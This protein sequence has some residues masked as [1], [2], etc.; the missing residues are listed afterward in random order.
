[1][2]ELQKPQSCTALKRCWASLSDSPLCACLGDGWRGVQAQQAAVIAAEQRNKVVSKLHAILKPFVL[3]RVKADVEISIPRKQELILYAPMTP[4]QKTLNKQLLEGS[5]MVRAGVGPAGRHRQ[6]RRLLHNA[7][8]FLQ[9]ISF[10]STSL[11]RAC[12]VKHLA[13]LVGASIHPCRNRGC[14]HALG[15]AYTCVCVHACAQDE[16]TRLSKEGGGGAVARL[17]NIMMQMRKICN[18]PDLITSAYTQVCAYMHI[19]AYMR[20]GATWRLRASLHR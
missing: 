15:H 13:H 4:L 11:T 2:F 6:A 20:T 7:G 3:R 12:A 1:M 9:S 19:Y 18:H 16:L 8:T 17:N 14:T 10:V 5:L